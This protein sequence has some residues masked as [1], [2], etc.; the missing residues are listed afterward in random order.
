MNKFCLRYLGKYMFNA[1]C[2]LDLWK[3]IPDVKRTK[4]QSVMRKI[5]RKVI[6]QISQTKKEV[7]DIFLRNKNTGKSKKIL[8]LRKVF[9]QDIIYMQKYM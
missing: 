9:N 1:K 3:R 7:Y 5:F 8:F 2:L 6:N 4:G